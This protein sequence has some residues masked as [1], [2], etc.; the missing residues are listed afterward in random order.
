M[1]KLS[2][3]FLTL[4]SICL[5]STTFASDFSLP[6]I[7]SAGLG[8]AYA[9]WA[10]AATDA[11]TS[12]ANPAGLVD[13]KKMQFVGN[14]LGIFGDAK[15][16]GTATTT[17]RGFPFPVMETGVAKTAIGAF[18]PSLYWA[19]AASDRFN[20]GFS[21][22]APFGLGTNYSDKSIVRYVSTRSYVTGIDLGPSF[23]LKLT[24][25]LSVGLGFDALRLAFQ[26]NSMISPFVTGA[27]VDIA[28]ENKL[29]GWGYGWHGGL[30]LKV[31]PTTRVGFSYNSRIGFT[32]RGEST[33]FVPF[34]ALSTNTQKTT[35]A[36][37]ARA[38][39]SVQHDLTSKLTAMFT[40][41]YTHWST[42]KQINMENTMTGN[43]PLLVSIPFN[44]HD[45]WDYSVGLTYKTSD[46]LLLRAGLQFM[47]T[48]SNDT[49]RG[50]ADPIGSAT[51]VAIGAHYKASDSLS[52]DVGVGHSFV[53][54]MPVNLVTPLSSLSG[55]N[56]TQT[57]VVGGQVNWSID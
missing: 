1:L 43:G 40:G 42:F 5:S 52:Y 2:K 44:Y 48:P 49:D 46:K 47:G 50:V 35:A 51:V 45:C 10:T 34:G 23:G 24:D 6:F 27:P 7:N 55:H 54:Q 36:V 12:Y 57:N 29:H 18:S 15:F 13:I 21:I 20:V 38:Q 33:L 19:G 39:I 11:S 17:P 14:A 9:D 3:L 22:T 37:P 53:D 30:L 56:N 41:F 28:L 26:L 32:T 16:S 31:A 4:S 8:V 25:Y